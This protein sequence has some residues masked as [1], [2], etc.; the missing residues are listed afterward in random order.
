MS[1]RKQVLCK[2]K[3]KRSNDDAA[4]NGHD[5][6]VK[7]PLHL[8]VYSAI[9]A[10][11]EAART[12]ARVPKALWETPRTAAPVVVLDWLADVGFWVEVLPVGLV[13]A[14]ELEIVDEG[15]GRLA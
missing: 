14:A 1:G 7:H 11:S 12:A 4:A 15:S 5:A 13:V 9:A 6:V 10:R 3:Q 2:K 8:S